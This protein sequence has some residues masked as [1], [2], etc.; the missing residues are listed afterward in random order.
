MHA[1]LP[2][3][4]GFHPF[5]RSAYELAPSSVQVPSHVTSPGTTSKELG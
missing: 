1:A 2:W 4:Y 5:D 3:K